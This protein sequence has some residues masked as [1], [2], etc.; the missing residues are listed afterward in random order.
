MLDYISQFSI[1]LFPGNGYLEFDEFLILMTKNHANRGRTVEMK[2]IFETFDLDQ[3]GKISATELRESMAKLGESL[4]I[5][6]GL[7]FHFF[8]FDIFYS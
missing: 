8:H 6:Q 7:I 1:H 2:K 3:S 5:P 4:S